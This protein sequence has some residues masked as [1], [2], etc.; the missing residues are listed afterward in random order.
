MKWLTNLP[1]EKAV[2]YFF[3]FVGFILIILTLIL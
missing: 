1:L 2:I 3:I